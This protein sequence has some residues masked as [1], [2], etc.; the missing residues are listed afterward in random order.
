MTDRTGE[1]REEARSLIV[2]QLRAVARSEG[3]VDYDYCAGILLLALEPVIFQY[4]PVP[5]RIV[6]A[7]KYG[8]QAS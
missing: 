3:A 7:L 8:N 2:K 1:L 6:K 5:D 4:A